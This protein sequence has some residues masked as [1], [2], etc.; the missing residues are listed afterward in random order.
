MTRDFW[1]LYFPHDG[2]TAKLRQ[3][4]CFAGLHSFAAGGTCSGTGA[5]PSDMG[6]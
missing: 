3:G 2:F 4:C 1:P 6:H 5:C